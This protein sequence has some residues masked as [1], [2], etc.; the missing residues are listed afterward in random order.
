MNHQDFL[1]KLFIELAKI[2]FLESRVNRIFLIQLFLNCRF[3]PADLLEER[4]FPSLFTKD[5]IFE[6]ITTLGGRIT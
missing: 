5:E 3:H 6:A 1:D 2:P 4:I